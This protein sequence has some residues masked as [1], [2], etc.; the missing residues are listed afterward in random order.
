MDSGPPGDY[1][2]GGHQ[3]RRHRRDLSVFM[4]L[5]PWIGSDSRVVAVTDPERETFDG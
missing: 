3:I 4:E 2:G 1:A 5:Y